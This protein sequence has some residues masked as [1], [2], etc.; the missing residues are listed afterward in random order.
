MKSG[1]IVIARQLDNRWL[2]SMLQLMVEHYPILTEYIFRVNINLLNFEGI[3]KKFGGH[4]NSILFS[5]NGGI[6]P[7]QIGRAHVTNPLTA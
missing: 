6:P 1:A 4:L 5:E 3:L 2:W 7:S